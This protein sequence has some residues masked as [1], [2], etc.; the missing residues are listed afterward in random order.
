[1]TDYILRWLWQITLESQAPQRPYTSLL[2]FIVYDVQLR[3]S[4]KGI[5]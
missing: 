3:E 4:V 2:Q 1:M 5:K